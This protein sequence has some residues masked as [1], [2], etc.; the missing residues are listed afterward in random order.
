MDGMEAITFEIQGEAIPQPRAHP[1]RFAGQMFTPTRTGIKAFREAVA[2]MASAHASRAGW[3]DLD[4]WFV[5]DIECVFPRPATHF[6]Q[7]GRLKASAP[8]FPGK[9]KGDWDNLGKGV[10]DA[11]TKRRCVWID[12]GRVADGRTHKRFAIDG[13][14]PKTIVTIK[15]V[16]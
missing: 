3:Q 15:R 5:V 2:L 6:T 12:D 14:V 16:A 4:G 8:P 9:M 13:E 1:G 10:C 11:I 7:G